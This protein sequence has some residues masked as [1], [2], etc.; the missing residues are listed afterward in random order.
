MPI[1]WVK[2]GICG[3][4]TSIETMKAGPTTVAVT[5]ATT[6]EH[7]EGLAQELPAVDV[8]TEMTRPMNETLTYGAAARHMC[9]T[10]CV[11]PAA[12][13]KAVEA[14]ASIFQPEA[15]AIEFVDGAI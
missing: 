10:S 14:A 2:A 9:R 12:V 1:C 15:C 13:L 7:V 6:C 3:Q 11:V 8:A 5:F 4:E